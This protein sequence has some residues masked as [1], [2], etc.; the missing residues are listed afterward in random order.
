MSKHTPG[1]WTVN[2]AG[3]TE[4]HR[5]SVIVDDAG[6]RIAVVRGKDVV[7]SIHIANAHL[8]SAAPDLLEACKTLADYFSGHNPQDIPSECGSGVR[9]ALVLARA[10]IAKAEGGAT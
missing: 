9:D 8:I 6:D 4:H 1:P 5:D 3:Y 10:A 7:D 2:P